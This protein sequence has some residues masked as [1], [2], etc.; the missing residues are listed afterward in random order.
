MPD[1]N[2]ICTAPGRRQRCER[3]PPIRTGLGFPLA[4]VTPRV[5]SAGQ[6]HAVTLSIPSVPGDVDGDDHVDVVDLLYLVESFGKCV[7]DT[8]FLPACDLNRDGY[9]DV[10]DLL[11]IVFSFGL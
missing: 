7:G 10:V 8:G 5:L 11:T 4:R 6:P 2:A 3:W 1:R 9:V